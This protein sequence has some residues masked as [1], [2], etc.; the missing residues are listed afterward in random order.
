MVNYHTPLLAGQFYHLFNRAV[1]K[2]RL[3]L[4]DDNYIYFLGRLKH[5]I[6]HVADIFA[7]SLL[8]NHFH[9]L[10]RIKSENELIAYFELKKNKPFD[11]QLHSLA[12]FTME[13][14][15]N[16]FNA[17]A[18]AFNKMYYR[19]GSLFID[20]LKRSEAIQDEDITSFIFYIHKNA[21]HHGLTKKIGE[22][23]HDS[24]RAILS[25]RPTS[26]KREEVIEWFGSTEQFIEFHDQPVDL[27]INIT[28]L[29]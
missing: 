1:G 5:Y 8:P 26:L 19:K 25:N 27:K 22:W 16:C 12:D 4:S 24:Y 15:S 14:F 13:Q 21:V 20:Y 9:M 7:Y 18:K 2:E 6:L 17:Y 3:F 11:P 28:D 23:S 10:A 29:K